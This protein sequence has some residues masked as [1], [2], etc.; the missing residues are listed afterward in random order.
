MH[1][2]P[3]KNGV[4]FTLEQKQEVQED[5]YRSAGMYTCDL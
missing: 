4:Q 3:L 1:Q 5:L 2:A